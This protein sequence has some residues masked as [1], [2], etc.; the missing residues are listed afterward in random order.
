MTVGPWPADETDSVLFVIDAAHRIE[1]NHLESWLERE[2]EKRGFLGKVEQVVVPIADSPEGVHAENLCPAMRLAENT[3]VVPVRVVWLKGLDVKSTT[4]R[5]RDLLL[6][7]PRRPGPIRARR[8]LKNHPMRAKCV[9]GAPATIQELHQ[10]LEHRLGLAPDENQ[11]ADFMAGQAS[12]ALDIAERRLRGSRYKV[13]RRVANNLRSSRPFVTGLRELS[14]ETG[15][16]IGDLQAEATTIFKELISVPQAFWLDMSYLLNKKI[17]TLGYDAEI[18]VDEA[19]LQRIRKI[20]KEHPAAILCTHKTHVDFPA[21]NK[22]LF[23]HD[24]PAL[25]TMGGVN[26]AFAGIG[27]LARRAGVIFIRRSFQDNPLYKLI[28]RQYIAY[29]MDKNFPLSWAFEGTRSRVGKLMPPKYGILKYVIEA[30]HANDQRRLHIIPV[31]MNYDLIGDVR[32]YAKEQSGIKKRPESLS[33]FIG[34]MRSLR[35]PM[36]KIYMDFGEPIVLDEVP[37]GDDR[38]ALSK[39]A[40]QVGVEANRVTPI[41]LASLATMVLL[42]S[43][44]RALT[45]DELTRQIARVVFWAQARNIRITRHFEIENEAEL[46]ALAQVLIDNRLVTRYDDGPEDV[47][48]IAPRRE[49]VASY[50]RNTIIHHFVIKAIAELALAGISTEDPLPLESFWQET[51]RLRDLFKFEFF[52]APREEFREEVTQELARY[53]IDWQDELAEDAEFGRRLLRAFKP[54]VA[55]A[56]LTQFVEAYY[57]VSNVAAITPHDTAIDADDCLKR[58]FAY[59]RQAYRQRR[60]SSEASIGKLLFQNGY[61]WIENRG[62]A[63]AGGPELAEQR[64]QARQGLQELMHR[65]QRIQALALPD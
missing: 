5:F 37:S 3:L 52:Y 47:Y 54:L 35:R 40:L 42:G 36:G 41:T 49:N 31:A 45:R 51:D 57:V 56:T 20:C 61:K 14:A 28:L 7:N 59:A 48:A 11:L 8:I 62:F 32:D 18:A 39:L 26:M 63:A 38:L 44:P 58:S 64:V 4:P 34:Y 29:L 55:H 9:S 33:W 60:I 13:P 46:T 10:R 22:V 25:H 1:Q 43:A 23:D 12:I 65:L 6:G 21:L 24:F 30:A 17:S 15:R 2:R 16:S 19:G 53:E 27:F 50:Y